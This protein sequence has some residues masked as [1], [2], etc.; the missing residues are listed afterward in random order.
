MRVWCL[1]QASAI[2][3]A[4]GKLAT[5]IH[6]RFFIHHSVKQR[7]HSLIHSLDD[8]GDIKVSTE[9]TLPV[10]CAVLFA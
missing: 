10:E 9:R 5:R 3:F 7:I 6:S 1:F 2:N 4:V 8:T